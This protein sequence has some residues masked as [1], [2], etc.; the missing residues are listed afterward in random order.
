MK[1]FIAIFLV[2]TVALLAGCTTVKCFIKDKASGAV[3][4]VIVAQLECQ[5]PDAVKASVDK[6]IASTGLCAES[7]TGPLAVAVCPILVKSVVDFLGDKALPS[8][9]KCKATTAKATLGAALTAACVQLPVS[10][11]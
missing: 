11:Q 3:S 6:L 8:E 5:A 7:P 9:W 10:E 4:N 1:K 2:M